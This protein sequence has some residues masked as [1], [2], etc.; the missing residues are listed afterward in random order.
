MAPGG[1][2]S[3][4]RTPGGG[5]GEGVGVEG[6]CHIRRKTISIIAGMNSNKHYISLPYVCTRPVLSQ[7]SLAPGDATG[8]DGALEAWL[9]PA[10]AVAPIP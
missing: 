9:D 4:P 3:A 5:V 1:T 2:E 6:V 10:A 8:G 7:A